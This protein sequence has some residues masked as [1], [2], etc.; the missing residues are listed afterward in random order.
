M[1]VYRATRGDKKKLFNLPPGTPL[2]VIHEHTP[3]TDSR[4]PG[5]S[6]GATRSYS[7]WIVTTKK[8]PLT[9]NPVVQSPTT[10]G[11]MS[12][13]TLLC[14]ELEIHTSRPDLPLRGAPYLQ[15]DYSDDRRSAERLVADLHDQ[16]MKSN[17]MSRR[18]ATARR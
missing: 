17:A 2:F 11:E 14:Q 16:Q 12:L 5:I 13:E 8:M 9:R 7:E 18:W 4:H 1:T 3:Y 10:R 6:A 15:D